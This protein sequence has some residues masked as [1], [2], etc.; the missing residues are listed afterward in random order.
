[1]N[2]KGFEIQRSADG[3]NYSS[4]GFVKTL[5][6]NGNSGTVLKYSFEDNNPNL[7]KQFYRLKQIDIDEKAKMSNV[8]MISGAKP[9]VLAFGGLYPNPAHNILNVIVNSP[10]NN[11]VDLVLM[12]LGGKIVE[13]QSTVVG[14]GSN[15]IDIDISTLPA[16]GYLIMIKGGKT[17][18]ALKFVK[19]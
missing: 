1:M 9:A 3:Q 13:N 10:E 14:E 6:I 8:I 5:G 11:R 15:S 17:Q 16:N 4:V 19:Q 18:N 2:C 7:A 12:E